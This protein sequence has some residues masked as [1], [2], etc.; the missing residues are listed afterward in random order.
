MTNVPQFG[1]S[2][3]EQIAVPVRDVTR[4]EAFYRDQLGM[5]HLFTMNGL[6]FF[7][8]QGIRLLLSVPEQGDVDQ[9]S[10]TLYFK[11]DDLQAAYDTLVARG[12]HFEDE[13]HFIANMGTY[14]LW[15]AFFRDSEH[16]LMAITGDIAHS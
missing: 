5:Q 2:K 12:V 15:M 13:P 4:A 9:Q 16:N 10:S 3:I 7:N 1:L 8:C 6:A 14:D 11:V